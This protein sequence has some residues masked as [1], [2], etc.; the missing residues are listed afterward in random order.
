[1][2][3]FSVLRA[4]CLCGPP[5]VAMLK[6][7]FGPELSC[8]SC[9]LLSVLDLFTSSDVLAGWVVLYA[10]GKLREAIS[11]KGSV[12]SIQHCVFEANRG[13]DWR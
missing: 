9:S 2:F 11:V 12:Q 7:G 13:Q 5:G 6:A 1:M 8:L 4:S 3:A 10:L